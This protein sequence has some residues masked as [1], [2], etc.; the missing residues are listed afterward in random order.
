[1]ASIQVLSEETIDKIAAGEVIERPASIIKE[2][3][4]NS[5]DSGANAI[6]IE[7]K[8]GGISFIRVTDNGCGMEKDD[9]KKAFLRH[10]TS[11]ISCSDDLDSLITLGFRGEALSSIAA[12]SQVELMTKTIDSIS[13]YRYVIEG[14]KEIELSEIGV[15][16]GTTLIVRNIFF[17]TPVRR[18]FLKS[19]ITE[20]GYVTEICEH[21]ALSRPD[22]SFKYI[23][24][25][26]IKFHTS[27]NGDLQELIYRIYGKDVA[28]QIIP[29]EQKKDAISI[30]GYL[31]KPILNRSTRNYENYF[32]NGRYVKSKLIATAIEDGYTEYLMQHKFPF[33]ILNI[34]IN[35][36]HVDVNVHP[37]KMEVRFSDN[38]IVN[39]FISSAISSR[40]RINEMI[41]E[42]LLEEEKEHAQSITNVPEPFETQRII[43][44]NTNFSFDII[45]EEKN[46]DF[47]SN[48]DKQVKSFDISGLKKIL[49]ESIKDN[50]SSSSSCKE[51]NII[52][53]SNAVIVNSAVQMDLFEDRILSKDNIDEYHI[54]GQLFDTYWLIEYKDKL[55][56]MDQHAAH[57]K[58]RF[59]SLMKQ[60]ESK[61]ICRQALN[62][63]LIIT[64]SSLEVTV[65]DKYKS[66]F[67]EMG[68]EIDDF[69]GN[70][71]SIRSIPMDL[72]GQNPKD[73]FLEV[74]DE[75]S[76]GHSKN[77][78]D[79]IRSK[80]ASMACKAAVKGNMSMTE[81]EVKELIDKLLSLDNPYNCPH[82]RP[83][84]ITMTKYEL[85]K[86]FKRIV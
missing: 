11:K 40:L 72:Y 7:I 13:G 53:A 39:D 77:V 41:P 57:E 61:N 12:I 15:P 69:G 80:I 22:I 20:A 9:I 56:I 62:P 19:A 74:L 27:G 3:V 55:L 36:E 70:E 44:E 58:I 84:L 16:G 63:A 51:S 59:E 29:I 18:K 81:A 42:C 73:M 54:V 8:D 47:V 43:N 4:E 37:T 26:Q 66:Y 5:I 10:A 78:P 82:G 67:E 23:I 6:T 28:A 76:E 38:D 35:P 31:G 79:V 14:S 32:I 83:T 34:K 65:F 52:K 2:L 50:I 75:L 48:N 30:E 46:D 33:V 71:I 45:S 1:M 49:G 60:L 86:K 21:L 24:G 85:E 64:L 68:F 25:G 17:N